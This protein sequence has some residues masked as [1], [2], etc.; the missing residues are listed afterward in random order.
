MADAGGAITNEVYFPGK[1][2]AIV[3]SEFSVRNVR[4]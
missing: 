2:T 4:M 1:E 3:F